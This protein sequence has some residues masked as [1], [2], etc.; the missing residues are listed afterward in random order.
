MLNLKNSH[1]YDE[2]V[3]CFQWDQET[4]VKSEPLLLQGGYEEWLNM[5]PTLTTN[6]TVPRPPSYHSLTNNKASCKST[7]ILDSAVFTRNIW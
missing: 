3:K 7:L 5:Y 1:Y 6:A 4:V 2:I